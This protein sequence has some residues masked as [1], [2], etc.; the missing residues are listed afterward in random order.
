MRRVFS[1][2]L[3]LTFVTASAGLVAQRRGGTAPPAAPAVVRETPKI[4]CP[5]VAGVGVATKRRFCDVRIVEIVEDGIRIELPPRTGAATLQFD[6]HNRFTAS[7]RA[8]APSRQDAVVALVD[9]DGKIVDR[10]IVRGE[11]RT[12]KDFFDRLGASSGRGT[13]ATA[14]GAPQRMRVSIPAG[15][16]FVALVGLRLDVQLPGKLDRIERAGHP[17]GLASNFEISYT[18]ARS[19]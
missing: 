5:S 2:V 1:V 16:A 6:L 12:E 13:I 3:G 7:A 19:R 17:I 10:G 15:A 9:K 4:V 14:P 18:P 8:V 11:L